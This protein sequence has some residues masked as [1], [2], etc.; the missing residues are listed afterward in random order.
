MAGARTT[1]EWI[2]KRIKDIVIIWG[3]FWTIWGIFYFWSMIGSLQ[4]AVNNNVTATKELALSVKEHMDESKKT[5]AYLEWAKP[6][7][8][9]LA[10]NSWR[11]TYWN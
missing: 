11:P 4:T 7:V 2:K 5:S 10:L 9:K 1:F 3:I 8:N 6:V